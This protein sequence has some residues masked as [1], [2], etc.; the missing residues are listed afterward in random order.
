MPPRRIGRPPL[1]RASSGRK[2]KTESLLTV[3]TIFTAEES[4]I[5]KETEQIPEIPALTQE[6]QDITRY[7]LRRP[8]AQRALQ[9][10]AISLDSQIGSLKLN[11]IHRPGPVWKRLGIVHTVDLPYW[12][13]SQLNDYNV[14]RFTSTIVVDIRWFGHPGDSPNDIRARAFIVRWAERSPLPL[15]NRGRLEREGVPLL[16][17]EYGCRG[18]CV[19]PQRAKTEALE[20]EDEGVDDMGEI[21]DKMQ[22]KSRWN[23]P[24]QVYIVVEVCADDLSLA[25]IWQRGSH[26]D[27]VN[28]EVL[29]WSRVLR[30][31]VQEAMRLCG[32]RPMQ[33]MKDLVT[34]FDFPTQQLMDR[35][36]L[37]VI[38]ITTPFPDWR[39]P[40][41]QKI[42][43]LLPASMRRLRL[44]V[45]PFQGVKILVTK[46]PED[47]YEPHDFSKLDNVS[48]FT[49]AVS[50]EYALEDLLV[51]GADD[52][53]G[54]DS[55]W[56]NKNE[57]RA[58][59]TLLTVVT[60]GGRMTPGAALLS[61]NVKKKT[62]KE[63]LKETKKKLM[64]R[65]KQIVKDP[66]S[67]KHKVPTIRAQIIKAAKRMV[68][69]GQ[70]TVAKWMID[71]C[72]PFLQAIKE[73]DPE[74]LI[75]ICQ[76]HIVTALI[77]FTG[78][79]GRVVG[80]PPI[81]YG[82]K[83]HVVYLFR[84]FQRVR[85]PEEVP[86][87]KARFYA[88]LEHACMTGEVVDAPMSED[89]FE[90]W[91][92]ISKRR[93]EEDYM[94]LVPVKGVII[95]DEGGEEVMSVSS[96]STEAG[97]QAPSAV[98]GRDRFQWLKKFMDKN[99]FADQWLPHVTDIS[100]PPGITRNGSYN[101]NN[102][103][104]SAWLTFDKTILNMR[105]NKRIDRLLLLIRAY[106][107]PM[108]E[109]WPP[110]A[111]RI[112]R[113]I[114]KM[115]A[116]AY[117]LWDLGMIEYREKRIYEVQQVS[118]DGEP[119]LFVV[120]LARP[121]CSPCTQWE[122][123]GKWC[124]HM[125]A[126]IIYE[127]NGSVREWQALETLVQQRKP[128]DILG[129]K[130]P[131]AS[132]K[133]KRAVGMRPERWPSDIV[134][135]HQIERVFKDLPPPDIQEMKNSLQSSGDE[136]ESSESTP[137]PENKN[138]RGGFRSGYIDMGGRPRGLHPLRPWRRVAKRSHELRFNK[139]PGR[140]GRQRINPKSVFYREDL[141]DRKVRRTRKSA[142]MFKNTSLKT[143]KEQ[144]KKIVPS[145][146]KRKSCLPSQSSQKDKLSINERK[147]PDLDL[148]EAEDLIQLFNTLVAPNEVMSPRFISQPV[149][150]PKTEP[151]AKAPK[152]KISTEEAIYSAEDNVLYS[153]N[154]T[155]WNGSYLLRLEEMEIFS[156][157][158][159]SLCENLSKPY[160]F[161]I[162][163]SGTTQG[164]QAQLARELKEK[165]P[166]QFS[167][168]TQEFYSLQK[169][170]KYS[171]LFFFDL[172]NDHW[173][174]VSY[175]LNTQPIHCTWH[176]SLKTSHTDI[177]FINQGRIACIA[178]SITQGQPPN[179]H[180]RIQRD[181]TYSV[182]QTDGHSCGFW[183]ILTAICEIFSITMSNSQGIKQLSLSDLKNRVASLWI[184]FVAS[185]E[186]LPKEILGEFISSIEEDDLK[187][188]GEALQNYV[189]IIATRP[190]WMAQYQPEQPDSNII[191]PPTTEYM[192]E[193]KKATETP[194]HAQV[195]NPSLSFS[196]I[197][198]PWLI[199]EDPNSDDI[200]ACLVKSSNLHI[201]ISGCY[202]TPTNL[203]RLTTPTGWLNDEIINAYLLLCQ[204]YRS[205]P[206]CY[207]LNSLNV[208]KIIEREISQPFRPPGHNR[209]FWV[210]RQFNIRELSLLILPWNTGN[211]W[212]C[213]AVFI[214][215]CGIR[216]YDSL[217]TCITEQHEHILE[218]VEYFL[219]NDFTQRSAPFSDT[220][221]ENRK[222]YVE[223]GLIDC[224]QQ[225]NNYDCG[226][227]MLMFA[228][229]L[230]AGREPSQS[231]FGA[232]F[233][234]QRIIDLRRS[235]AI[236]FGYCSSSICK[237]LSLAS[238]PFISTAQ[239]ALTTQYS[240]K[241]LKLGQQLLPS[242]QSILAIDTI[243][244]ICTLS[245]PPE[246]MYSPTE[247]APTYEFTMPLQEYKPD[248]IPA[249]KPSSLAYI[250]WPVTIYEGRFLDWDDGHP[251]SETE[252]Q[253]FSPQNSFLVALLRSEVVIGVIATVLILGTDDDY[254]S[255]FAGIMKEWRNICKSLNYHK[256]FGEIAFI[257]QEQFFDHLQVETR[258]IIRKIS[259]TDLLRK[260]KEK[261][262]A[263]ASHWLD[264]RWE[265]ATVHGPGAAL[266]ACYAYGAEL[267]ITANEAASLFLQNRLDRSQ[268]LQEMPWSIIMQ[269][270]LPYLTVGKI[271]GFTIKHQIPDSSLEIPSLQI[272][273]IPD[274][275]PVITSKQSDENVKAIPATI[276]TVMYYESPT[277]YSSSPTAENALKEI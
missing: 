43:N 186:G 245:V 254:A 108:Y 48:K 125:R 198:Y 196:S 38:K 28:L 123:T 36:N 137:V 15:E 226:L 56:R 187:F 32:A 92:G 177:D 271:N 224:P 16:R 115:Y 152:L 106:F 133:Q 185:K 151:K 188:W 135:Q 25:H 181:I 8:G 103:T 26:E 142:F 138:T 145:P 165:S 12:F 47:I 169:T 79:N 90:E 127:N 189:D 277:V 166:D 96:A 264:G 82:L 266:L 81:P 75:I 180:A 70:W 191:Q 231:N 114:E 41:P 156:R 40:T 19:I 64:E 9:A 200:Y 212:I 171:E 89:E 140:R 109:Q 216:I 10:V 176:N 209:K 7:A 225:G 113:E 107:F 31:E 242:N 46:N 252:V 190:S 239:D 122:Q 17:W 61:A 53:I 259:E 238:S 141:S 214:R 37:P 30:N 5:D 153:D 73:I 276:D 195:I 197:D 267:G 55:S 83:Y 69:T 275:I 154:L 24:N 160:Y 95:D 247:P 139:K 208:Q 72:W 250:R 99:W 146:K 175:S 136:S 18:I 255:K 221:S 251:L 144:V 192:S 62:I 246:V 49:V 162:S 34:R 204:Q 210:P 148:P 51:H 91:M 270:A 23:C 3:P 143:L 179:F 248:Q 11:K 150:Y 58:A 130:G 159:N 168:F 88:R 93:G 155:H 68:E 112:P 173:T 78:D 227:Y 237:D 149:T 67:V 13:D 134:I 97:N 59:M 213:V 174:L 223:K 217:T 50:T 42:R 262:K 261:V 44:H 207:I 229:E 234:G 71:K 158:L 147:G 241:L 243:N 228:W 94:A 272:L 22:K 206:S 263:N 21:D 178:K 118:K 131:K 111:K 233:H 201:N 1:K 85:T 260:I 240:P 132:E 256:P 57:N 183:A 119:I 265:L 220:W 236:F 77:T 86:A 163:K 199:L 87:Y 232:V 33:I 52:G 268:P 27:A 170:N 54:A 203:P 157:L 129:Y 105:A 182:L 14:K 121:N 45:D 219:Q 269:A 218:R 110:E 172:C 257:F 6:Q 244:S 39:R 2:S 84:E 35:L 167:E 74:F 98:V 76:F 29:N 20:E 66:K 222:A 60:E 273:P 128:V 124:V 104:E 164:W 63:W 117:T 161:L 116:L 215:E 102:W 100:L 230:L 193:D 249:I 126:A 184:P 253:N 4:D 65:A 120:D 205:S 80:G 211:H 258:Y 235:V 194:K 202:I 101:T 274:A